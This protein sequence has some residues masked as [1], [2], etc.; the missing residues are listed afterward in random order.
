[1]GETGTDVVKTGTAVVKTG[2]GVVKTATG[3][4]RG[5]IKT[6]MSAWTPLAFDF[7]TAERW[8]GWGGVRWAG[9]GC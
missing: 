4:A 5:V 1:M 6:C 8:P 9:I 3:G 2:T 7:D